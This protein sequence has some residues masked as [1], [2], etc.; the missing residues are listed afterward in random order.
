MRK[1]AEL[2]SVACLGLSSSARKV[3]MSSNS[4]PWR[5]HK[6]PTLNAPIGVV[7]AC[8]FDL[9]IW[10]RPE[11]SGDRTNNGNVEV[12]VEYCIATIPFR[13]LW[14]V[15]LGHKSQCAI[16]ASWSFHERAW[17]VNAHW[18]RSSTLRSPPEIS[19]SPQRHAPHTYNIISSAYRVL[20]PNNYPPVCLLIMINA[21]RW[22]YF[23]AH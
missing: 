22:E 5:A 20:S 3:A 15:S 9:C 21:P 12:L 1:N 8:C 17:T 10:N 18:L 6:Y 19:D 7:P 2:Y 14:L 13:G 23:C 4:D 11:E 16:S